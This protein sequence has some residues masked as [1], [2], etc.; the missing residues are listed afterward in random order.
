MYGTQLDTN[1]VLIRSLYGL[2]QPLCAYVMHPSSLD[3]CMVGHDFA[4][5]GKAFLACHNTT[6]SGLKYQGP[7]RGLYASGEQPPLIT[8]VGCKHLCGTGIKYYPWTEARATIT[9]WI[10]PVL[11][12][13]LQLP[14]ESNV[15]WRT[16]WLLARWGGR[17][18]VPP[19]AAVMAFSI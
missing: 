10:L 12:M 19:S 9:A 17:Y 2:F 11:G 4:A 7:V 16:M 14:Y 5:Y 15:F 8:N 6:W 3:P 1:S 13:F 18:L